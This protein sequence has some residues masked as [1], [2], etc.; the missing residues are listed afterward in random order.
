MLARPCLA[1]PVS[2][3]ILCSPL[4]NRYSDIER[5]VILL[6]ISTEGRFW[7][8]AIYINRSWLDDNKYLL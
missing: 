3:S 2:I 8:D 6:H 1:S 7:Q 5:D 4:Y